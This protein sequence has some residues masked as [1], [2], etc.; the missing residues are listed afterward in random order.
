M[1]AS[2]QLTDPVDV[3]EVE[4]DF[5]RCDDF[6]FARQKEKTPEVRHNYAII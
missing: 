3:K 4:M 2:P 5:F 1:A 6:D